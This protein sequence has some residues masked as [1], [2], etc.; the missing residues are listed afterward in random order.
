MLGNNSIAEIENELP[1]STKLGLFSNLA[2]ISY[3]DF[4]YCINRSI[5]FASLEMESSADN[6]NTL[7][8]DTLSDIMVGILKGMSIGA[9]RETKHNGHCDIVI[10]HSKKEYLILI[11]AKK[12]NKGAKWIDSGF[13]Q[14]NMRYS[15]PQKGR[16][17]GIVLVYVTTQKVP[18]I[19]GEVEKYVKKNIS[20]VSGSYEKCSLRADA[21]KVDSTSEKSS[22]LYKVRFAPVALNHNPKD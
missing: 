22:L 13:D 3:K 7:S 19:M 21:F 2:K 12:S 11:E 1:E 10:R 17:Y 18:Y 6:Y 16:D 4:I 9:T 14:L 20:Y 15:N 5:E 8:E